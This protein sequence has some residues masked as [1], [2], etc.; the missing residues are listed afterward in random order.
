MDKAGLKYWN[1][2][3]S[4]S[5]LPTEINPFDFRLKNYVNLKFHELFLR[6]FDK[7]K[8]PSMKL[9]EIGCAKSEWLPY[10]S[11]EFG[12][13]V[14]GLDYSPL[15]C[16][17]AKEL[18]K[19]SKISA[20]IVC[21]DFFDPPKNM[22]QSYDILLSFGVVEHF[23][24]TA[25]SIRAM[26][27]FIKPGGKMI[28]IIPNMVGI[29]GTIQKI[30]NKPVYDIHELI[31]PF[32]LK[33]AHESIGLEVIECDYFISTNFGVNNLSGISAKSFSW[34][35]KKVFLGF[36]ARISM[37]IWFLESRT[38]FIFPYSKFFSPYVVCIAY[39]KT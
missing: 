24:D 3:W 13:R 33:L 30:I 15:G 18:L 2:S 26:S 21:A 25:A 8:T 6:V 28:T 16:R 22:A 20:D 35:I 32:H 17:M 5:K 14:S 27:L 1:N 7:L 34:I 31:D 37:L 38:G 29:I 9:I 23:E 36:F 10:F 39:K 19:R 4:E 12:F 11:R